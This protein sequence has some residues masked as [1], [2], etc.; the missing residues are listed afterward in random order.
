MSLA[1]LSVQAIRTHLPRYETSDHIPSNY[2][3]PHP[4]MPEININPNG[5]LKLVQGLKPYKAAGPDQIRPLVLKELSAEISPILSHLFQKSLRDGKMP[6]EWRQANVV[7]IYKK[8]PKHLA[9]NYRPVSLTCVCC[10]V[11]E[12]IVASNMMRH[13]EGNKILNGKQHGFRAKHSCET[14]LVELV[15]ELH[16]IIQSGQQTDLV[17]MDFSKAFD[18]VSHPRLLYK[19]EWYGVRGQTYNWIR[20][21]LHNR[22]QQ[23]ILQGKQSDTSWVS[24]GVPQGSVLGPILFLIYINDLPDC[25]TSQVRLFAD[26]T[27]VYRKIKD[28]RDEAILQKDLSSLEEWENQW[29]MEFHPGKCQ[30]IRVTKALKPKDTEY[31]LHGHKLDIV[32]SAKYLG[33]TIQK[34]LKWNTHINQVISKGNRTLGMLRRNL[35]ISSPSI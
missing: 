30:V 10:K 24:S 9:S 23:V 32:S 26:D 29:Q 27:I 7:P 35:K 5:V 14:Q 31:Y 25:V 3:S 2:V 1:H 19:L 4:K 18:K 34:D 12:H 16:K 28:H 13:L 17:V 15:H 21:F 8:G 11:F 33:L 20:D 22:S 6:D